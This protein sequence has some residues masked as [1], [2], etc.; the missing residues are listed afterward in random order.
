MQILPALDYL[1]LGSS[2]NKVAV[3]HTKD[4]LYNQLQNKPKYLLNNHAGL[5]TCLELCQESYLFSGCARG[6]ICMYELST[7]AVTHVVTKCEDARPIS[8]LKVSGDGKFLYSGNSSAEILVWRIGPY[9]L[10]LMTSLI[11]ETSQ[12]VSFCLTSQNRL[13]VSCLEDRAVHVWD[14]ES[15][16]LVPSIHR[17]DKDTRS[18]GITRDDGLFIALNTDDSVSW[19]NFQATRDAL[20][21][22]KNPGHVAAMV[23]SNEAPRLSNSVE[24]LS[25]LSD[26]R[27]QGNSGSHKVSHEVQKQSINVNEGSFNVHEQK[28]K[29]NSLKNQNA[30]KITG[31][32]AE[33]GGH[34]RNKSCSR[35]G[36]QIEEILID[37]SMETEANKSVQLIHKRND[38]PRRVEPREAEKTEA[39]GSLENP[40]KQSEPIKGK[41]PQTQE[42]SEE[43]RKPSLSNPVRDDS[44][45]YSLLKQDIKYLVHPQ[46]EQYYSFCKLRRD[47]TLCSQMSEQKTS[48]EQPEEVSIFTPVVAQKPSTYRKVNISEHPDLPIPIMPS[49]GCK[50]KRTGHPVNFKLG[51]VAGMKQVEEVDEKPPEKEGVSVED[52]RREEAPGFDPQD[53]SVEQVNA[54]SCLEID[55]TWDQ[56]EDKTQLIGKLKEQVQV[57]RDEN[58]GL[59]S[60]LKRISN[61]YRQKKFSNDLLRQ[62]NRLLRKDN[63]EMKSKLGKL[64]K[65]AKTWKGEQRL[66]KTRGKEDQNLAMRLVQSKYASELEKHAQTSHTLQRTSEKLFEIRKQN[67]DLVREIE[68]VQ[69]QLKMHDK[70]KREFKKLNARVEEL[71]LQSKKGGAGDTRVTELAKDVREIKERV[72][73]SSKTESIKILFKEVKSIR[74]KQLFHEDM[75]LKQQK[76]LGSA[77]NKTFNLLTEVKHVNHLLKKR[78]SEVFKAE[79]LV[80][81]AHKEFVGEVQKVV[82]RTQQLRDRRSE[83]GHVSLK[84]L[85]TADE[86]KDDDLIIKRQ[87][88]SEEPSHDFKSLLVHD[89]L[90]K[91]IHN[92]KG[93]KEP[94]PSKRVE[95]SPPQTGAFQTTPVPNKSQPMAPP[96]YPPEPAD[97]NSNRLFSQ[98]KEFLAQQSGFDPTLL[99]QAKSE[100]L[101]KFQQQYPKSLQFPFEYQHR[102]NMNLR[103][104]SGLKKFDDLPYLRD[105]HFTNHYNHLALGNLRGFDREQ[106]A[107]DPTYAA[108]LRRSFEESLAQ[109]KGLMDLMKH[110]A[111][112]EAEAQAIEQI[113]QNSQKKAKMYS[114]GQGVEPRPA[115]DK[116]K[117][118]CLGEVSFNTPRDNGNLDEKLSKDSTGAHP[119]TIL[120]KRDSKK[121]YLTSSVLE[122]LLKADG[123]Q[124]SSFRHSESN[125]GETS[126]NKEHSMSQPDHVSFEDL[127]KFGVARSDRKREGA[128]K[129]NPRTKKSAKERKQGRSKSRGKRKKRK[130]GKSPKFPEFQDF[131]EPED[132]GTNYSSFG[133]KNHS[134]SIRI[135]DHRMSASDTPDPI[136][137]RRMRSSEISFGNSFVGSKKILERSARP[138]LDH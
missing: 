61:E 138:Q 134:P 30:S 51:D 131:R 118:Q 48:E 25:V 59:T 122:E 74:E 67:T 90:S 65:K 31:S 87:G 55:T 1:F 17:K 117:A 98:Y 19:Y 111:S 102:L 73:D 101:F 33:P 120:K 112:L 88:V 6:L 130:A 72:N 124:G 12:V 81:N 21:K 13:L 10:E 69:G 27:K 29:G 20:F 14:L 137:D 78:C 104:L 107:S 136:R 109:K 135:V 114:V 7:D 53:R 38:Q 22:A 82:Q 106:G 93:A 26:L 86:V 64:Q 121:T 70:S 36:R 125:A 42:T 23:E 80:K 105:L 5:V 3:I 56:N 110:K 128:K 39:L 60:E 54:P 103:R 9:D 123:G 133:E 24:T 58:R 18:V 32:S 113:Y 94:L 11:E 132:S 129:S 127:E 108:N 57:Y 62:K 116:G 15:R 100:D 115:K 34:L 49:S 41:S 40:L 71:Y 63:G 46:I 44:V 50:A 75:I 68:E 85:K 92:A 95:P 35:E 8:T 91:K 45:L 77:L 52:D 4:S 126:T 84:K 43:N 79:T 99:L 119:L 96:F 66:N 16:K 83:S 2:S 97:F 37:S 28:T 76:T 89:I 47:D